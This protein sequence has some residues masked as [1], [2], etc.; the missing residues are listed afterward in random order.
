MMDTDPNWTK[1]KG[2]ITVAFFVNFLVFGL[3]S[4]F[5]GGDAINGNQD[6]VN[7]Y[8]SAQGTETAV[9][10]LVYYYSMTHA[11]ITIGSFVLFFAFAIVSR[12][13][14]RPAA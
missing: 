8:L 6:G 14:A 2:R 10:P 4:V 7:Y 11:C 12:L 13:S 1:Y 5:I 3:I 9:H